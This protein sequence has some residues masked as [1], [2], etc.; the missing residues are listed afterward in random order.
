VYRWSQYYD[1]K[2]Q[3]T[4]PAMRAALALPRKLNDNFSVF[5]E[6]QF[7]ASDNKVSLRNGGSLSTTLL[8]NAVNVGVSYNF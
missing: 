1:I 6:Y 4:G 3:Y 7:T 8:T 2:Y 5:T